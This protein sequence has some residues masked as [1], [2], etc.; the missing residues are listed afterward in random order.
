MARMVSE[1]KNGNVRVGE[2]ENLSSELFILST[3][4]KKEFVIASDNGL[5]VVLDITIDRELMLEGLSRE[6]IRSVQVMRK[7]AGFN[8]E[9]RID[10]EFVTKSAELNEIISKFA[11]KI[12]YELLAR[13]ITKINNPE[14]TE[15]T[16]ISD[17]EI[18]VKLKR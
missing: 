12:K 8:V 17:D 14:Y 5:S 13:S 2:F 3:K 11:N 6:L 4:P 16:T 7:S 15:T 10:I 9:D 1:Y 18:T